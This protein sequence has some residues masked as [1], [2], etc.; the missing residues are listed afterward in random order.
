M[1]TFHFYAATHTFYEYIYDVLGKLPVFCSEYG[2]VEASGNGDPDFD[3]TDKWLLM[4]NGNNTG[5]QL[6]SSCN[7]SYCDKPETSAALLPG[8]CANQAWDN[9]QASGEY[10]R[11]YIA[12]MNAGVKDES[13]LKPGNRFVKE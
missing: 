6:V 8:S 12:V 11:K 1:Y 2:T 3:K 5:K 7:W 9:V 10:I 13:V 4:F